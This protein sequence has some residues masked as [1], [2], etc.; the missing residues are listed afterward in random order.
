MASHPYTKNVALGEE[1]RRDITQNVDVIVSLTPMSGHDELQYD[2]FH[3]LQ[4]QL[5]SD[6]EDPWMQSKRTRFEI[7]C[8]YLLSAVHCCYGFA[9]IYPRVLI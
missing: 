1:D 2:D 5:G 8:V 4:D 3:S 6:S 9:D 7:R